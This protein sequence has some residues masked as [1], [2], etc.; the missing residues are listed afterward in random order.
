MGSREDS[1]G[2]FLRLEGRGEGGEEFGG[3]GMAGDGR[4]SPATAEAIPSR[5]SG[6]ERERGVGF[7][8]SDRTKQVRARLTRW[9]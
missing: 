2:R 9:V 3:G 6:R 8:R 1:R 4:D 5:A 7:G